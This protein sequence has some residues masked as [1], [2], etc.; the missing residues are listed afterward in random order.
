MSIR[1][2][3][4][5]LEAMTIAIVAAF[6]RLLLEPVRRNDARLERA[7]ERTAIVL[8][9][10]TG[11]GLAGAGAALAR[12][13]GALHGA[14]QRLKTRITARTG[15]DLEGDPVYQDEPNLI[16]PAWGRPI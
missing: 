1:D 13:G 2:S 9:E 4:T 7:I 5:V 11:A 3:H 12:A 15:E 6:Y 16:L 8:H 14:G 10:A